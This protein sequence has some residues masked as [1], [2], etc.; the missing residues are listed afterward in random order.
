MSNWNL[1]LIYEDINAWEADFNRI[2]ELVSQIEK[3]NGKLNTKE[4][5][6]E[7]LA[8]EEE[9]DKLISKLFTYAHM[10]HDLNQRDNLAA[11]YY[12]RIYSKYSQSMAR[13]SFTSPQILANGYENVENWI[14]DKSE[15]KY[16]LERLFRNQKHILDEKSEGLMANYSEALSG[17]TKLY[18]SL[19]VVDNRSVKVTLSDGNEYEIN[20]SN[21]RSYLGKLQN[22]DDRRIVFEAVFKF[23]DDHK[24][25]FAGIYK[26]IMNTENVS[27]INRGYKNILESHLYNNNISESVFH[28]LINT[29]RYNCEPLKEYINLRKKYFNL[30]TYHTYDRFLNLKESNIKLDYEAAKNLFFE[31]AKTLGD[32]FYNHATK[33]L[34]SG[35]VSVYPAD[36]KQTGAYSTGVYG[37]GP[38][39]LLNHNDTLD[40]A[41]T[42]AHEAGHSIHTMY[43]AENQPYQTSNYVIFVAEVASTFNEQLLL[44]HLLETIDDPNEKIVLLQQA[45]DGLIGTFYR[46]ALFAN[47]EYEAHKLVEEHKV[48]DSESLS[49]IMV[50]LYKDYYDIDLKCEP[51]KDKVWAYIPHLFHS[52]FYVYQYATSFS[53]S[54]AIYNK[55]KNKEENAFE[56]YIKLLSAGGSDYPIEII[57]LAGVD[58]STEE[59]FKAVVNRLDELVKMLKELL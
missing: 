21:Y 45:I 42:L 56:N 41:F 52:P 23:Y 2:D 54:L 47:F 32:D 48:V 30:E 11:S 29:A 7:F 4:G 25:T 34:E 46:Q 55:V 16:N 18:D 3:F 49:K 51:Y 26:G 22:Q 15:Y 27:V 20:A 53:A 28:S 57:K 39:I 38:F 59:P 10:K 35:R 1:S 31:A 12:A 5:L 24:T 36:G 13:I 33:V 43:S 19:A 50:D 6:L 17:F 37:V 40:D 14:K 44:D 58:L 9:L 8:V